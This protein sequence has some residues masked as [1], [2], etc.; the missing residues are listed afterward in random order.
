M[1]DTLNYFGTPCC[2]TH[3]SCFSV[4]LVTEGLSP[5]TL[6]SPSW[7][8]NDVAPF[9]F[10]AWAIVAIVSFVLILVLITLC[11]VWNKKACKR[12]SASLSATYR[13]TTAVTVRWRHREVALDQVS[14]KATTGCDF[15]PC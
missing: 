10:P 1:P 4:P 14:R 15:V 3:A 9:T 7:P 11:I 13:R 6:E 2:L 8:E 12:S 5:A